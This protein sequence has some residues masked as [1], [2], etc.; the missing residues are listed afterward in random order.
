MFPILLVR[1]FLIGKGQDGRQHRRIGVVMDIHASLDVILVFEAL[2]CTCLFE[3]AFGR[4][5]RVREG[6][7]ERTIE[8]TT[9][10]MN[11]YV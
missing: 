6:N 2:F 1:L 5:T 4:L 3:L 10:N 11:S 8:E 9:G 7:I